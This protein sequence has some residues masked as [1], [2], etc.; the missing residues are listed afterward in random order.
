M[1]SNAPQTVLLQN[2]LKFLYD[3][4]WLEQG[5]HGV[6]TDKI[7]IPHIVAFSAQLLLIK[8]ILPQMGEI[9]IGV[10]AEGEHPHTGIGL[11]RL[12]PDNCQDPLPV[13]LSYHSSCDGEGTLFEI[14]CAP[15]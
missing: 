15:Y 1:K 3:V 5:S 4:I 13:F 6:H 11:C 8:L 12:I 2:L 14:D 10:G 9:L 7:C